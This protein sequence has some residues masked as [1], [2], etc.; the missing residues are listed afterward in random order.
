MEGERCEGTEIFWKRKEGKSSSSSK[1]PSIQIH[2]AT[3]FDESI[4]LEVVGAIGGTGRD[5]RFI[6]LAEDDV[7]ETPRKREH[8]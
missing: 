5:E 7:R 1:F 2:S 8:F 6:T 3:K 4:F